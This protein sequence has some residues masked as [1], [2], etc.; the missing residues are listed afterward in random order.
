MTSKLI[1]VL[2][3]AGLGFGL[4]VPKMQAAAPEWGTVKGQMVFGGA[5]VPEPRPIDIG[6]D[7]KDKQHCLSQGPLFSEEWVINKQN[8]GVRWA[9]VW[10]APAKTDETLPVHPSLKEIGKK[11]VAID[12]PACKFIPHALAL[13]QGQT[14]VAKNSASVSH[15]INWTGLKNPGGNVILP[16]GQSHAIANLV[17]D[18]FPVKLAC[19]IHPWMSAWVRV[20]DHPYFAVT[21]AN[22]K[23]EI[24]LAP[25]GNYHL[26]SWQEAVGYGPGGR[27]GVPVTIKG[28]ADTDVGKLEL[29]PR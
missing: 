20:F 4:L 3:T 7:N 10:L 19:N 6:N 13:R 25:A 14:L 8:K 5:T 23:F 18:R 12:Q 28:G 2:L 22:G 16:P 27:Q 26:V 29:T 24:K 9:F 21:D 11:E 17:A 1:P 15:N